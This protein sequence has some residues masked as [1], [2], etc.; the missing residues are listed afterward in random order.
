[1]EM[2][3]S[4]PS[5]SCYISSS[6]IIQLLT[7]VIPHLES[8]EKEGGPSRSISTTVTVRYCFA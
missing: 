1:M 2:P 4:S 6:I 8:L 7:V 5:E 3:L